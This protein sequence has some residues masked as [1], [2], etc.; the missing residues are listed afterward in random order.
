MTLLGNPQ[1]NNPSKFN[2]PSTLY[3]K[4]FKGKICLDNGVWAAVVSKISGRD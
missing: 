1:L 2:T 4:E 3:Q